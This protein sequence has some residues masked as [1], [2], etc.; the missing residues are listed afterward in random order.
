MGGEL[1]A[2]AERT[3]HDVL[4]ELP[5]RLAHV[6]GVVRHAELVADLV[7]DGDLLVAAAWL[8]DVGYSPQLVRTGFHPVDGA[9]FLQ[10]RGASPRLCALVANHSCAR[11]EARN[12]QVPL[13][14]PDE[15]GPLRDALWWADMSTTPTGAG[16]DVR[17]RLAEVTQRYGEDHVVSRS[18]TEAA[19]ELLEAVDR[20]EAARRGSK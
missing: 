15:R 14:W 10:R 2:W 17:A 16:T 8:H 4:S 6:A 13:S 9:E 3:A 19:P 18:L 20:I 5:T 12:R 7:D 1:L 11:V